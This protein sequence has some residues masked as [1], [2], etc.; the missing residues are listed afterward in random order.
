MNKSSRWTLVHYSEALVPLFAALTD[1]LKGSTHVEIV[2][3]TAR[4]F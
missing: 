3:H 1:L 4:P 2:L